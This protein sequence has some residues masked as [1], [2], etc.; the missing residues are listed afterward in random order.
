MHLG[1]IHFLGDAEV[2]DM[3]VSI[4]VEE[5]VAGFDIAVHDIAFVRMLQCVGGLADN[6]QCFTRWDWAFGQTI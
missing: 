5:N 1:V 4:G 3:H 6:F 2:G